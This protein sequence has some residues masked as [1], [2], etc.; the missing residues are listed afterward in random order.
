MAQCMGYMMLYNMDNDDGMWLSAFMR[1][2]SQSQHITGVLDSRPFK[3]AISV[4]VAR[5]RRDFSA[6]F[7][8]LKAA[9]YVEACVMTKYLDCSNKRSDG[10]MRYIAVRALH[11]AWSGGPKTSKNMVSLNKIADMICLDEEDCIQL[12]EEFG[13]NVITEKEGNGDVKYV[14]FCREDDFEGY[15]HSLKSVEELTAAR[16]YESFVLK[17][18]NPTSGEL[19]KDEETGNFI[20]EISRARIA[21]DQDIEPSIPW[22]EAGLSHISAAAGTLDKSHAPTFNIVPCRPSVIE[23]LMKENGI[24]SSSSSSSTASMFVQSEASKKREEELRLKVAVKK[25]ADQLAAEEK[26]RVDMLKKQE[27]MAK[28]QIKRGMYCFTSLTCLYALL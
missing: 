5:L 18:R 3:F 1:K 23:Q 4:C 10:G 28:D 11:K 21:R 9:P 24:P 15:P 13:L 27:Q 8:L 14:E 12:M 25:K 7:K 26:A 19:K 22:S 20:F 16:K 17:K 2:L 6:F